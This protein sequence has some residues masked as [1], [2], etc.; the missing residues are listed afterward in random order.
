MQRLG[1]VGEYARRPEFVQPHRAAVVRHEEAVPT[2]AAA[3][4]R[5]DAAPR[6]EVAD[7][8]VRRQ[9]EQVDPSAIGKEFEEAVGGPLGV[10]VAAVSQLPVPVEVKVATVV[11][12]VRIN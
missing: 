2:D 6:H 4:D 11:A 10:Q 9:L 3:V 8:R 1:E 12:T 7:G 5:R